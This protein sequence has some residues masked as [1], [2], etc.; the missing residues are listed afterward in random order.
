MAASTQT[1][2]LDVKGMDC[3]DCALHVEHAVSA[4]PGVARAQVFLMTEK[5]IVEF[6]P[7]RVDERQ[8]VRAV[9]SVGYRASVAGLDAAQPGRLVYTCAMC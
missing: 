3:A 8:I 1:I 5:G 2:E 9:E 7:A 4:L 6:D